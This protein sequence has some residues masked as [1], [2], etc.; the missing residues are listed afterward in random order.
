MFAPGIMQNIQ[1]MGASATAAG[2]LLAGTMPAMADGPYT[3]PDLP[4]GYDA[5]EPYIDSATMKVR[6]CC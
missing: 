5:L 4:Y 6:C 2:L 1:V 3:L